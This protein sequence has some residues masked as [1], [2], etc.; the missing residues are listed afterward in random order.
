MHFNYVF[1]TGCIMTMSHEMHVRVKLTVHMQGTAFI[2]GNCV[3][4]G[5]TRTTFF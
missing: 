1:P 5:I 4:S 3:K 2:Y